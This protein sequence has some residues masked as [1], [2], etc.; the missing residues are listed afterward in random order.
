MYPELTRRYRSGRLDSQQGAI[1]GIYLRICG[2]VQSLLRLKHSDFQAINMVARS[3]FELAL[4]LRLL[5]DQKV[6]QGSEKLRA[7][8]EVE[9]LK[10]ARRIIEFKKRTG[11]DI[12][13]TVEE[14]YVE[15]NAERITNLR[16]TI[17]RRKP[18]THWS[19]YRLFPERVELAGHPFDRW[20]AGYYS[21]LS[22]NVHS[23][24]AGFRGIS[25]E[26]LFIQATLATLLAGRCYRVALDATM[27]GTGV[28]VNT[29]NWSN[30]QRL[31]SVEL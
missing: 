13:T 8:H 26:G 6:L 27:V 12:D 17:W 2:Q 11:A 30:L 18:G 28:E 7:F 20:Y 10:T 1:Y 22:W 3:I 31:L 16:D 15:Q 24:L 19:G 21:K 25:E 23:G 29:E 9:L 14:R 4:D 5:A